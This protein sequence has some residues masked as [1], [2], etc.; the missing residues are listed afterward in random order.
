MQDMAEEIR[1]LGDPA[2]LQILSTLSRADETER[3][4]CALARR[5]GIS[6][7]NV[8]HHLRVLKN[9]G[10]ISCQKDQRYCYYAVNPETIRRV[11]EQVAQAILP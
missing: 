9:A 2:R 10:F 11:L 4:V 7:P 8:S 5:L 3:S 1:V 6:Q